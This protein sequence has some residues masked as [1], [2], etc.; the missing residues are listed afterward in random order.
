MDTLRVRLY[1]VRFGDAL[2][3]SVPDRSISGQIENCN[4][5][6]D[7]GNVLSGEGGDDVVF[8]PVVENVLE[9]LNEQ[10]LGLY[11]MTHEHLDHVQGLL[12]AAE[13]LNLKISTRYS[14]LTA[15]SAPDYYKEHPDA[16]KRLDEVKSIYDAVDRYLKAAPES[17][18]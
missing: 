16:K 1:N 14:W 2:L 13:K 6:I 18:A 7:V 10:P 4:I 5:L 9:V 8:Q 3:I 11:V 15:S 12:H 17:Q